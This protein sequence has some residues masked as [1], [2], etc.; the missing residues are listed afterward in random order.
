M[1]IFAVGGLEAHPE[2][3]TT[4][5]N[6]AGFENSQPALFAISFFVLFCLLSNCPLFMF[7]SFVIC[8]YIYIYIY[9]IVFFNSQNAKKKNAH[10][11]EILQPLHFS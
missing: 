10:G 4:L 7:L 1:F 5:R 6:F 2:N 3:F 9:I 8:I 11:C